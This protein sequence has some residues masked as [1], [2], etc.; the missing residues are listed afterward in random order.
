MAGVDSGDV[1][2]DAAARQAAE[3]AVELSED[4]GP[5]DT[6]RIAARLQGIADRTSSAGV[7]S[8]AASARAAG[9]T[10]AARRS[11]ADRPPGRGQRPPGRRAR[12]AAA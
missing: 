9:R 4:G 11:A 5:P 3:V 12:P 7:T 2:D 1:A 8:A 10:R 6:R